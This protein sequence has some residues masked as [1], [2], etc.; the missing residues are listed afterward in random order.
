MGRS[1]RGT[2]ETP[3]RNRDVNAAKNIE[4][5]GLRILMHPEDTGS[6]RASGGEGERHLELRPVA[7]SA[8][9]GGRIGHFRALTKLG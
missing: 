6:V 7:V 5:E 8:R 3:G 2:L 4:A 9:T 1:A